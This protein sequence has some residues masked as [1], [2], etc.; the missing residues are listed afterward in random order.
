VGY[1]AVVDLLSQT[2]SSTID[3]GENGKNPDNLMISGDRLFTLNNKDFTGSSV[4]SFH[5]GSGD[6]IT[7]DLS[8]ISAGCGT[9]VYFEGNIY[10]QE[11]FST[12]LSKYEPLEA[13]LLDESDYGSSFY[14]IAFDELN[15]L[16]YTSE[17]DY[18]SYG[19]INI[20]NEAGELI[21]TFDAGVSPGTIVFDV[22]TTTEISEPDAL[23][24]SIFPNPAEDQLSITSVDEMDRIEV[25]AVSGQKIMTAEATGKQIHI[26]VSELGNGTYL[27]KIICEDEILVRS[28]SKL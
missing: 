6:L 18:L 10:Y 17:T 22:R 19:M 16:M 4:S 3:L 24:I 26:P 25:Y 2:L 9:S 13:E 14:A 27:I 5:I 20:F 11:M 15:N 28:F 1:L 8:N 12:I 7:T 21:Y 23:H